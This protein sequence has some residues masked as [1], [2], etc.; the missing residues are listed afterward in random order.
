MRRRGRPEA[1]HEPSPEPGLEPCGVC[2]KV[3]HA[4]EN[5]WYR[6]YVRRTA[7]EEGP[8]SAT[9]SQRRRQS[10]PSDSGEEQ[11]HPEVQTGVVPTAEQA[12]AVDTEGVTTAWDPA[13]PLTRAPTPSAPDR[14]R[15]VAT[16]HRWVSPWRAAHPPEPCVQHRR[17]PE[18]PLRQR[19]QRQRQPGTPQELSLLGS[20][21]P[22]SADRRY[23]A[24]GRWH[25]WVYILRKQAFLRKLT[26]QLLAYLRS[27]GGGLPWGARGAL[28]VE[29]SPPSDNEGAPPRR[30][31]APPSF[32]APRRSCCARWA[33]RLTPAQREVAARLALRLLA[34]VWGLCRR[35]AGPLTGAAGAAGCYWCYLGAP[36]PVGGRQALPAP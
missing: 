26:A 5:C 2:Q 10:P 15:V 33:G 19:L 9:G 29:D 17:Q 22:G 21:T 36:S 27:R 31:R 12:L 16:G 30:R 32:F 25:R 11:V 18:L 3:G 20:L 6:T 8:T 34:W 35:S 23:A 14:A 1:A 4:A 24:L 13:D 7:Q 28:R